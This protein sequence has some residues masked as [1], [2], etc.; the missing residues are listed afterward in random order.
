MTKINYNKIH[1]FY[2]EAYICARRQDKSM[3]KAYSY[4]VEESVNS[5]CSAEIFSAF[6]KKNIK[7]QFFKSSV[8][9]ANVDGLRVLFGHFKSNIVGSI[10]MFSLKTN[11]FHSNKINESYKQLYPQTGS[12]RKYLI[13]RK[14][15]V[16]N[17]VV[18]VSSRNYFDSL[19]SKI[20][21]KN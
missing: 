17:K 12:L 16:Y 2:S 13:N 19:V 15:I 6:L 20:L 1:K 3:D 21:I 9:R 14:R 18:P 11:S 5:P 7:S 10:N 8:D 4:F